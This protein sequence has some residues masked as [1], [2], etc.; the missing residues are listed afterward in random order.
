MSRSPPMRSNIEKPLRGDKSKLYSLH[1]PH[2]YCMSK[3]K[4]HKKYEF[5]TKVSIIKTR[6]SHIVIGAMA[7]D[8]NIYDGHSLSAV[9]EQVKRLAR[10][11][12]NIVLC[13]RGYRGKSTIGDPHSYP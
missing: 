7:F 8:H 4:E 12:P 11:M 5:G 3:G 13:D 9:L 1:K 2:I 10:Y 6:D